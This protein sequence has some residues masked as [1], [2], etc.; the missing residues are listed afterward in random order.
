M[1]SSETKVTNQFSPQFSVKVPNAAKN[2]EMVEF[3]IETTKV[4][5][6]MF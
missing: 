4:N 5:N 6:K 3:F 1:D 2:G